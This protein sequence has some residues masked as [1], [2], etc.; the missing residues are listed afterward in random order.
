MKYTLQIK[1][2]DAEYRALKNIPK[3]AFFKANFRLLIE[4]I[5][6]RK[7]KKDQIGDLQ[8]RISA[9]EDF[10]DRTSC[11]FFDITSEESL[12]N[13]QIDE[14][15]DFQYGYANW[16]VLFAQL[17]SKYPNAAPMLLVND[18]DADYKNF[19]KQ[20]KTFAEKY[21]KIGYKIYPLLDD[22]IIEREIKIIK[23]NI[24]N[25]TQI[26][27]F[28]DQGYIVDGLIKIATNRAIDCL[29]NVSAIL[30]SIPNVEYIFTSTSFPDSVTSLSGNMNGKIKCSE[31][32]LYEQIEHSVKAIKDMNIS[33]SDYGS[34]TPKRNDETVFYSRGW[35]PRIDVPILSAQQ[36]YYY[37]QKREKRD[38]ADVYV[39]V[40]KKCVSDYLFPKDIDCWGIQT[41]KNAAAGFKPGATPSFWLSVRMNIFIIEQL[42]RLSIIQ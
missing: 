15:Y 16:D 7:S 20:V 29:G 1:T 36:I 33:Y 2:G 30:E 23:N 42:K 32:S 12:S 13:E 26:F 24:Q 25:N 22:D 9:L 19:V 14:L 6:G 3:D 37:R 8:K 21:N 40:A 10:L 38:Y 34:I 28:Y 17:Q 35:T 4:I 41:I 27:I 39:D 5:R 11:V 18:Q 31:I